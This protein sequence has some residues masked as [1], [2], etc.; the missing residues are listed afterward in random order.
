M[1]HA[2]YGQ[3]LTIPQGSDF[4]NWTNPQWLP[5]LFST[6]HGLVAWHPIFLLALLG[7]VPLWKHHRWLALVVL[8]AFL[9]QWYINS[10][11]SR[12]WADDAFGGRRFIGTIPLLTLEFGGPSSDP[13]CVGQAPSVLGAGYAAGGV[14]RS[15]LC[16]VQIGLG[17]SKRGADGS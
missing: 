8:V 9:A 3:W 12:W 1:W 5:T 13:L 14:E 4:F 6:R 10:A 11:A 16:A 15:E 17:E 2:I 7:I